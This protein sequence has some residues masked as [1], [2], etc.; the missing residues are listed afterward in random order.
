[1]RSSRQRLPSLT[2]HHRNSIPRAARKP[3]TRPDGVAVDSRPG[4]DLA[5][6]V[7]SRRIPRAESFRK[8]G[9]K[10]ALGC[11]FTFPKMQTHFYRRS[12]G[13]SH[14]G[15][16]WRREKSRRAAQSWIGQSV[17]AV[18]HDENK[19][20]REDHPGDPGNCA[21]DLKAVFPFL[22]SHQNPA[23]WRFLEENAT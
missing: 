11:S 20:P 10:C 16:G 3:I 2:D 9:G 1:M 5:P 8:P 12:C 17:R 22:S 18:R 7:C 19:R 14:D 13:F 15:R 4:S 6:T 21:T 23:G